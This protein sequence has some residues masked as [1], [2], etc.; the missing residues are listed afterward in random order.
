MR[1]QKIWTLIIAVILT[2]TTLMTGAVPAL[3]AKPN[4]NGFDQFGYNNVARIF[5]GTGESWS[6]AKGFPAD[7][8]GIYAKDKL[9]MKWT[10]D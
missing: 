7:Y 4:D 10:A 3:A 8:L 2:I 9:V 6:L 5:N 1:R